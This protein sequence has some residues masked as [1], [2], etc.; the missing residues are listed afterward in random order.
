MSALLEHFYTL[1]YS[2]GCSYSDG[3]Q[4]PVFAASRIKSHHMAHC[5]RPRSILLSVY[6]K[7]SHNYCKT[8]Q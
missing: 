8:K 3:A 6:F 7:P 5:I 1:V 4:S 2:A